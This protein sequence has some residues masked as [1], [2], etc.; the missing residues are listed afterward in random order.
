MDVIHRIFDFMDFIDNLHRKENDKEDDAGFFDIISKSLDVMQ[1][2]IASFKLADY[3]PDI[4]IEIPKDVC[5][6]YEFERATELIEIG[7]QE[8]TARLEEFDRTI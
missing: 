8:A 1:S 7:R 6:I 4:L 3:R 5:T 2:T